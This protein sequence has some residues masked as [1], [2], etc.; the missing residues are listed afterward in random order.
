MELVELKVLKEKPVGTDQSWSYTS[1]RL[2]RPSVP[3]PSMFR[4]SCGAVH[5]PS[6]RSRSRAV[7]QVDPPSG[8]EAGCDPEGR[9]MREMLEAQSKR[10]V[11][12]LSAAHHEQL[13]KEAH[14]ARL[15]SVWE[16]HA[17]SALEPGLL[18]EANSN[19]AKEAP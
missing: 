13:T 12:Q 15:W 1:S 18:V 6:P 16:V 5:A 14:R 17:R 2:T 8:G 9:T 10:T 4:S 11:M 3:V 19:G 7:P